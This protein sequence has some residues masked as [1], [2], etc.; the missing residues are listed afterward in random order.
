MRFTMMALTLAATFGLA[1][2]ER[3]HAAQRTARVLVAVSASAELPPGARRVARIGELGFFTA[4]VPRGWTAA[5]YSSAL[6][7]RP[8]IAGAEPN[9]P[10]RRASVSGD[11]AGIPP[12]ARLD[13]PSIANAIQWWPPPRTTRPVAVLD[14]GVDPTVPELAGRVLPGFDTIGTAPTGLADDDGHG[15]QVASAVAGAPGNVAGIAPTTPILPVRIATDSVPASPESVV[16]GLETAATNRAVAAVLAYSAPLISTPDGTI[17][18][19]A[20]AITAAFDRGVITVLPSGNEGTDDLSLASGMAHALVVGS[21]GAI[22]VRDRFSSYGP[23]LDLLAPGSNLVLPAP[24]ALCPS[25]YANAAGTSFAAGAVAGAVAWLAAARPTLKSPARVYDLM[26]RSATL[27]AGPAGYDQ[28]T[29]YGVLSVGAALLAKRPASD[30]REVNDDVFWLKRRA[31]PTYLRT[32]RRTTLRGSVSPGKDP[33]DAFKVRLDENDVLRM[34]VRGGETDALLSASVWSRRT[35]SFDMSR[36]SP[37]TELRNSGGFTRNPEARYVAS[38]S[39]THYVAV[40]APDIVVPGLEF[41]VGGPVL[42]HMTYRLT[43]DRR[44]GSRRTLRVPLARLRRPGHRMSSLSVFVNGIRR[45][46]RLRSA[47]SSRVVLRG[48][49]TRRHRIV[50]KA[51]FPTRAH[52]TRA[53]SIRTRCTLK[54]LKGS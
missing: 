14:T 48:L 43:I 11:C 50:F 40:F 31:F 29:G 15:T 35:G 4:P 46:R 24:R 37:S 30:P 44:C 39:G 6:A 25:G 47:I 19:V 53:I 13:I 9:V 22:P 10:L 23:W 21:T 41:T 1:P 2:P 38:R 27:D 3:A 26:R 49:R 45:V 7:R 28:E 12:V 51:G 5:R 33:Q 20:R 16:K 18:S 42:P 34:R 17:S 32:T 52:S 54:V 8:G 36:E